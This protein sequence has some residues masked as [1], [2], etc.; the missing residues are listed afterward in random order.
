[1]TSGVR[2][3]EPGRQSLTQRL[4]ED[5]KDKNEEK[6]DGNGKLRKAKAI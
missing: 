6:V 1:M 5:G 2:Q 3:I 4:K